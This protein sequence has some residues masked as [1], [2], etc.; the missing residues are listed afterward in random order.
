MFPPMFLYL[1][2]GSIERPGL[3]LWLP[4][5]L[6][7]LILLP[8]VALVLVITVLVDMALLLAGQSYHYYTLLLFRGLGLLGATRGTVVS[9][10]A[11]ET[12][13]DLNLV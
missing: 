4:L 5:F 11:K 6:V 7:W 1:R 3:G 9:I 12:V 10:R 2:T 13:V 8:I